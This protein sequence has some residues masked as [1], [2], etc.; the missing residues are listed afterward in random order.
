[1]PVSGLVVTLS[2]DPV[3]RAAA[4]RALGSC[5]ALALGELQ[6]HR[7][8]VAADTPHSDADRALW[9]WLHA[10]PGVV[11]VDLVCADCSADDSNVAEEGRT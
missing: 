4:L 5:S 6:Q 2:H 11:F 10:L 8:P 3:E 1:M 7:L 9:A